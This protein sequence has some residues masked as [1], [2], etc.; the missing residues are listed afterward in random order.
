MIVSLFKK[1]DPEDPGNYRGITLLSVVGKLYCKILS[2]RLVIK[3]ESEGS[4][5]EDQA[6]FRS[7]R[8][9]IDNVFTLNEIVQGRLRLL[10][11]F[12]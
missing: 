12:S 10:M 1:G 3:L 2:N 5:H 11:H 8:S 7:G 9:C 6:G 4:I